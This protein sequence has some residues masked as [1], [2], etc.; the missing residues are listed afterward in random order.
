MTH[1]QRRLYV[2]VNGVLS[3]PAAIDWTDRAVAWVHGH[4][5]DHADKYEYWT[6]ALTR[7][8]T[9]GKHAQALAQLVNLH[10]EPNDLV[11][12]G[13]SNG[14]DLLLR[15]LPWIRERV[16]VLHLLSAAAEPDF[17]TNGLNDLLRRNRVQWVVV[18][19][20]GQDQALRLAWWSR[21]LT[22]GLAGYGGLGIDGPRNVAREL[23]YAVLPLD[24]PCYGHSDWFAE[25]PAFE[26]TMERITA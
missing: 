17:D 8:L 3:D 10:S 20:A 13:H 21:L 2:F 22:L 11:L 26:R 5:L 25:G 9:Q 12:V 6:W 16:H 23:A 19:R 14:C 1:H 18:W 15:A 4:T 24:E 7:R